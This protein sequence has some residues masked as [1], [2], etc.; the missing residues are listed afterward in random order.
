MGNKIAPIK[1][2]RVN[3]LTSL[4]F[5]HPPFCPKVVINGNTVPPAVLKPPQLPELISSPVGL[6]PHVRFK[7]RITNSTSHCGNEILSFSDDFYVEGNGKKW[8]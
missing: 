4:I 7:L 2:E 6:S 8:H 1:S 3:I 5:E